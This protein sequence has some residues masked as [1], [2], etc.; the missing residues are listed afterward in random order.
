VSA[1][2]KA[3]IVFLF[4]LLFSLTFVHAGYQDTEGGNVSQTNISSRTNSSW[5]GICGQASP[6]PFTSLTINAT[7][8]NI[9]FHIISTSSASC[10][11]AV[12]R[13]NLLFSNSS[14]PISSLSRGNL[15]T[16][17][18][19]IARPAE[20]GS[21]TF[22]LSRT[23]HTGNYGTIPGVPTTFTKSV[24]PAAFPLSYLNDQADNLVFLTPIV[25]DEGGFNGSLFDFQLMLPTRNGTATPYYITIDLQCKPPPTERF[26]PREGG[27]TGVPFYPEGAPPEKP[28]APEG[29]TNI[30]ECIPVLYCGEWGQCTDGYRYKPCKDLTNCSDIQVFKV[31]KC[32][33]VPS[34][35][36]APLPAVVVPVFV[37]KEFPCLAL[38]FILLLLMLLLYLIRKRRHL[39]KKGK[40][41]W[42]RRRGLKK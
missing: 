3:R 18:T 36:T 11:H 35:V 41:P 22:L 10:A 15:T 34:N 12:K 37:E 28:P 29:P 8:G 39:M 4:F 26:P 25:N 13:L 42:T 16:L 2:S 38:L 1:I 33:P 30:T 17:D 31:G 5:H 40:S 9:S 14:T 21:S 32:I 7:P 6:P 24:S 23:I 19:F 27:G 20:S